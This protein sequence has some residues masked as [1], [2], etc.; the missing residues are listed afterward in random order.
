MKTSRFL[1]AALLL[2]ALLCLA[3]SGCGGGLDQGGAGGSTSSQP[4]TVVT[5]VGAVATDSWGYTGASAQQ[6]AAPAK[7]RVVIEGHTL[8]EDGFNTVV[9]G[10]NPTAISFSSDPSTLPALAQVS[11]PG[12]FLSYVSIAISTAWTAQPAL[13]VTVDVPGTLTT[14]E[15]VN[16]YRYEPITGKWVSPQA[17]QVTSAGQVS[18]QAPGMSTYGLFK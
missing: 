15:T 1:I 5:A 6:L 18:F 3:L 12:S 11:Q 14:G 17:V 2:S 7:T 9:S 8:L 13:A 10:L 16:V 4:S